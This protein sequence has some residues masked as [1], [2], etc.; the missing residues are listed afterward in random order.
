MIPRTFFRL[1]Q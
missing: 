1:C